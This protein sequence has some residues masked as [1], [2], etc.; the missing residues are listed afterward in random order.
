MPFLYSYLQFVYIPMQYCSSYFE[1]LVIALAARRGVG[2]GIQIREL[3]ANLSLWLGATLDG[4]LVMGGG[5]WSLR[6]WD[7]QW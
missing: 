3:A 6:W 2:G 1:K 7:G 4:L 5:E